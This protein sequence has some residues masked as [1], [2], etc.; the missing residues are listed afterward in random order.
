LLPDAFRPETAASFDAVIFDDFLP[1]AGFDSPEN[2]PAAGNFLFIRRAPF[3]SQS[4][5]TLD[6]PPVTD[7]DPA[8]PLLRLVD[9]RNVG[10]LRAANFPDPTAGEKT[11][12]TWHFQIPVRSLGHPLVLTGERRENAARRQRFAALAFGLAESDLPLRVAFPLF[13]SNTLRWLAGRDDDA[14][15]TINANSL[16]AGD[17]VTLLAGDTLWTRPQR[18]SPR[19]LPEPL[20]A[21][22]IARG[23]GVFQPMENGFYLLRRATGG[24]TWLAV[25]TDDPEM[26]KIN[27]P[28]AEEATRVQPALNAPLAA[29]A[30]RWSEALRRWPPWVWCAAAALA[31]SALEWRLFHRRRT[32]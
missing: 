4:T 8:S 14:D 22:E 20:P 12:Q 7:L 24:D 32:E 5:P 9:W 25:N 28:A 16:R 10:I 1:A 6:R 17:T 11:T 13:M 18:G 26:S 23:P 31:L 15:A 2:L 3:S 27:A 30:G 29:V 19:P 21:T